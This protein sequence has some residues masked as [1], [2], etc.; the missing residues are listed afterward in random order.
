MMFCMRNIVG[1][2][3]KLARH[4]FDPRMTQDALA[5][6]LQLDGWDISR[7]GVAKIELGI[8]QVT[9]VEVVRLVKAL[10]VSAAWLLGEEGD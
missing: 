9:D 2:R 8:R 3:V 5:L 4:R 1:P 10:K 6:R 7:T